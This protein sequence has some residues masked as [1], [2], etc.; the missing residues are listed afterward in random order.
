LTVLKS[1]KEKIKKV[2]YIISEC[3]YG[4]T[5]ENEET[6]EEINSYLNSNGFSIIDN[7]YQVS[8]LSDCLW[9]NNEC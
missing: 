3:D 8:V 5:R 4:F 2:K 7:R 9:V 6:F 1:L